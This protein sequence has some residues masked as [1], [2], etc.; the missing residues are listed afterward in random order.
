MHFN[1]VDYGSSEE[2]EEVEEVKPK[3]GRKKKNESDSG[4]DVSKISHS[5]YNYLI[6]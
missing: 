4:S 3:V 5:Y 2:E 6:L 1:V